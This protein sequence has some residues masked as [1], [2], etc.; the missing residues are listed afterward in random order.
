[1]SCNEIELFFRFRINRFPGLISEILIRSA[2]RR[3]SA[4]FTCNTFN[5]FGKDETNVQLLLQGKPFLLHQCC[6]IFCPP[7]S[8]I[9]S[10]KF[11]S[12]VNLFNNF[13]FTIYLFSSILSSSFFILLFS[14]SH[15]YSF[16]TFKPFL[17][18]ETI[19]RAS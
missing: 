17:S 12:I 19:H 3:D 6:I 7:G 11:I 18:I 14:L 1:M 9:F 13:L 15:N 4:L 16:S 5:G 2:D 8:L 10:P